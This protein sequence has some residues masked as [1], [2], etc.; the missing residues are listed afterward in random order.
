M[1]C[2]RHWDHLQNQMFQ[3]ALETGQITQKQYSD[4][5]TQQDLNLQTTYQ[6]TKR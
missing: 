5:L 3:T 4:A 1:K 2:F 6:S